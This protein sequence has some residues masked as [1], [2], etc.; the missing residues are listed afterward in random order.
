VIA[1]ELYA[2][3]LDGFV[4]GWVDD[5]DPTVIWY[6][7]ACPIDPVV[8][9]IKAQ[10]ATYVTAA[11]NATSAQ[12]NPVRRLRTIV[13]SGAH[14]YRGLGAPPRKTS[15]A[16]YADLLKRARP[17]YGT[18]LSPNSRT[19]ALSAHRRNTDFG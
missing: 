17:G 8:A 13:S 18:G 1:A 11:F 9:N 2:R 6:L 5:T 12:T 7:S 16:L 10:I 3:P 4:Y 19:R 15:D 14:Q